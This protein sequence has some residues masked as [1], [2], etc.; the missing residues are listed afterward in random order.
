MSLKYIS[1]ILLLT[2]CLLR[3]CYKL[4]AQEKLLRF[5][6][7]YV[8]QKG[9]NSNILCIFQDSKGFMWLGT[10]DGL[11][12]YDGYKFITYKH[13]ANDSTS[14]INNQVNAIAEDS[15]G[16]LW[17]GTKSGLSKY[18]YAEEKFA[19]I[20]L[21]SQNQSINRIQ[22]LAIDN[23]GYVWLGTDGG[24]LMRFNPID[25]RLSRFLYKLN[26]PRENAH[27]KIRKISIDKLGNLWLA[28]GYG[29]FSLDIKKQNQG[30][31]IAFTHYVHNPSDEY[32]L[33]SNDLTSVLAD[34]A[35]D[36]WVST[37]NGELN[38]LVFST[39]KILRKP[40]Q[41]EEKSPLLFPNITSLCQSK[42]GIVWFGGYGAGLNS[43]L[44][45]NGK[46][47]RYLS[48]K[49]ELFSISS[50]D[51]TAIYED[52]TGILWIATSGGGLHKLDRKAS[53]FE[54]YYTRDESKANAPNPNN[55]KAV[56]EDRRGNVWIGTAN[57]GLNCYNPITKEYTLFKNEP[58][59]PNSLS[60][61]RINVLYEDK[62]GTLWVGTNGGGLNSL[63][64]QDKQ[65]KIIRY[66]YRE[67]S[68]N[69]LPHDIVTDLTA[70]ADGNL[71]IAT[72]DGLAK[73]K[74]Q[75]NIFT[76]YKRDIKFPNTLSSNS[77]RCI[78]FAPS[79]D[80][81]IGTDGG[82][83]NQM[84][85]QNA[86]FEEFRYNYLKQGS[87]PDDRI[88]SLYIDKFGK[89]W[90]GTMGGD[91]NLLEPPKKEF[92]NFAALHGINSVVH[93]IIED[94]S[95]Q[96]WLSGYNG[97]FI[98][99]VIEQKVTRYYD[100]NDG[101]PASEFNVGAYHKGR[102]GK[103][104]FGSLNGM[105]AFY[106]NQL[107]DSKVIPPIVITDF[108]IA[109]TSIKLDKENPF[110]KKNIN[111]VEEIMLVDNHFSFSLEF[112]A[113]DY[114]APQRIKYKYKLEAEGEDNSPWI[115]TDASNR[116]AT[117]TN[118]PHGEYIFTVMATNSDGVWSSKSKSI[119]IYVKLPFW[120]TW[121]AKILLSLLILAILLIFYQYR[122]HTIKKDK[123]KLEQQVA[124]RT[125]KISQQKN[126]IEHQKQLLEEQNYHLQQVNEK[127][128][129]SEQELSELNITKNRFFSILAHDLRAPINSMKGFS[130]LLANFADQLSAEEIKS[131]AK[132]LD[133]TIIISSRYLE[134]LLTWARS[135]MNSIEFT[136]QPV[137]LKEAVHNTIE[138][139]KNNAQNKQIILELDGNLDLK[140]FVDANQLNVILTNLIS[141]AIKF[142]YK[143][144]KITIGASIYEQDRA[145]IY[146]SDTG[147]GMPKE[148]VE[149]IFRIDSKHTMKGTQGET[150]TGLGLLLCR[151][152]VEKN[153]GKIWVESTER[154]GSTFRFILPISDT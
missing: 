137:L 51:I 140:L 27:L 83:L 105:V 42:D 128:R 64:F 16:N 141:N 130:N 98:F 119:K 17:I 148:V 14:I 46:L 109:N 82:G 88:A 81:W 55:V 151:E 1:I 134:N 59:N 21:D 34:Q 118:L 23:Y 63:T 127:L 153:G 143:G 116:I 95:N 72:T 4:L 103:F 37:S 15:E 124:E 93:G 149:K 24:G 78:R 58:N 94:D 121:W 31:D 65:V 32:S 44:M 131:T 96:F 129:L 77:L 68:S 154:V 111:L 99:D 6:Q 48:N 70:D 122:I 69:S 35:G 84:K 22:S 113:L 9:A 145:E 75:D 62:F 11:S 92:K 120:K 29:L 133:E 147:T 3:D 142:T 50:N 126:E 74:Q 52:Q 45:A 115:L 125:E 56:W 67:G 106:P 12:K 71:W 86:F 53:K 136:P 76:I 39:K 49:N 2:I 150:G 139:L 79:G 41:V 90:V 114:S 85:V 123:Q 57:N 117:Y 91:L 110:F 30:A 66:P 40:Y 25:N 47:I 5:A 18:K 19:N 54:V 138:V 10:T 13:I 36:I 89:I 87:L 97:L 112:A 73:F 26:D 104:Y 8:E 102:S 101:L 108:K 132:N 146:I 144:G 7:V 61:N 60:D 152:F 43:I 20:I 33:I 107:E 80:L 28:T 38:K 135:Q 100:I